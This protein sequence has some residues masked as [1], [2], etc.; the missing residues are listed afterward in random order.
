VVMTSANLHGAAPALDAAMVAEAFAGAPG[1]EFVF[2]GGPSQ[3]G[4]ASSVLKLGPGE[5]KLLREGLLSATDL[6]GAAGLRIG[7]TCTGNTCR[8][9]MAEVLGRKLLGSALAGGPR[10]FPEPG[11]K[12]AP[13]RSNTTT[14]DPA[15]FGFSLRSMGVAAQPGSGASNGSLET[16]KQYGC[17]LSSHSAQRASIEAIEDLDVIYA[18]TRSHA[19][20]LIGSLPPEFEERVQL[21]DPE[22]YDIS[23]PIGGPM[24]VYEATARQIA[25]CIEA[26]IADWID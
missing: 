3:T 15:D 14:C 7:F 2:D 17:D 9:P 24:E 16:V 26:R 8:S 21:I 22:G 1:L 11:T 12:A 18:L 13:R 19:H 25:N 5:F 23:D 10:L 6:R 20:A 4:D